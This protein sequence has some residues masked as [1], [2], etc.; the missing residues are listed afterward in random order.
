ML[1]FIIYDDEKRFLQKNKKII[2]NCMMNY[3]YDYKCYSFDEY[4]DEFEKIIKSNSNLKVYLL[5]IEG[6]NKSGLDIVR[7]IREKYD[8]WSSII[9]MITSHN[10]FKYDAL[11]N[12]LY[13][14]DFIN[15]L[16]NWDELL[17]EDIK[18][19][20]NNYTNN[21]E[22]LIYEFNH[23]L[24]RIEYKNIV[25]IEKEKDS[26]KC[27]IHTLYG[28]HPIAGTISDTLTKLDERFIKTSRSTIINTNQVSEYDKIM[29]EIIFLNGQ[30]TTDISRKYKKDVVNNV[31]RIHK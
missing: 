6:K 27:I 1:N 26:K 25:Y 19:I 17:C 28:D 18:H 20:I 21:S 22:C 24:K 4:N 11:G 3:D 16:D 2:D 5:D 29:N 15:K 12:R 13:L 31:C 30:K 14:M 9:I 10:E 8:D 23:S 7:I